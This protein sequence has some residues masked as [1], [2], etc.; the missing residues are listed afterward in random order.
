[1][2]KLFNLYFFGLGNKLNKK[3]E[4]AEAGWWRLIVTS[5]HPK[6]PP[7]SS[8][9]QLLPASTYFALN[10]ERLRREKEGYRRCDG[11]YD[12]AYPSSHIQL[13]I[14][15]GRCF[16]SVLHPAAQNQPRRA[17]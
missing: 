4:R 12:E 16:P 14:S 17:E 6:G 10:K 3:K 2:N 13:W 1:M 15:S 11:E 8:G 7:R 5:S 9:W